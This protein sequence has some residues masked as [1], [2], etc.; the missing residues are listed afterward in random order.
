[1]GSAW[2]DLD[3]DGADGRYTTTISD[4]WELAVV[5]Q[6]GVVAAIAVRAMERELDV[7]AQAL[8]TM[9]AMFA[10]RVAGGSVQVEVRVLRRGRSMSQ[11]TATVRTPGA[12]AGLT[13]IA[14][15]GAPRRGFEFTEL[16][17]PEVTDPEDL[18][19][20]RDPIPAGVDFQFD[21]P[22]WPFWERVVEGRPAI[23]R[24]PW[25]PFVDGPAE[26]A[27]WYRLDHPPLRADGRLDVAGA[28]VICDTMPGP[29]GQK[30][31]Q[32]GGQWFAPSVDLTFHAFGSPRPHWLLAHQRAR[33]AGDGY[34]S[35]EVALWDPMGDDGPELVAYATQ[36]MLFSFDL[37]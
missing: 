33:H 29:I 2:D 1:M 15:F 24:P 3:L 23:G 11:L 4:A 22:P 8:R 10:G 20:F 12:E 17:M 37:G 25:E 13:A 26:V 31:G 30:V 34:A 36:M 9:T 5:P 32:G 16:V 18:R 21:G 27:N 35:V 7:P 28:I 14:A 6:G 19:G